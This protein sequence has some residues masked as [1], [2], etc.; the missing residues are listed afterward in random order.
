MVFS[1]FEKVCDPRIEDNIKSLLSMQGLRL[2]RIL[3]EGTNMDLKAYSTGLK[4]INGK[5]VT[6]KE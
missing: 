3:R 2:L 1:S 6:G 4:K 5:A